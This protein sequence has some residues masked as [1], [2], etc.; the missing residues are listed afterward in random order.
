MWLSELWKYVWA[1]YRGMELLGVVMWDLLE[2]KGYTCLHSYS[3]A[4]KCQLI[5][6]LAMEYACQPTGWK[7]LYLFG[8]WS[9]FFAHFSIRL[10]LFSLL[11]CSASWYV[12]TLY[13]CGITSRYYFPVCHLSFHFIC[14][15]LCQYE[16][17]DL[18]LVNFIQVFCLISEFCVMLG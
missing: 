3:N 18:Y 15:V 17:A 5:H 14:G 13:L 16:N 9:V 10:L 4:S 7:M 1:K 11:P 6:N 2:S 8:K 12:K